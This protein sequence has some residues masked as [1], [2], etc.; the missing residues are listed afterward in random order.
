MDRTLK[1]S[2]SALGLLGSNGEFEVS[3]G[4]F[5]KFPPLLISLQGCDVYKFLL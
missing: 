4:R 1:S 3:S 2:D 5:T